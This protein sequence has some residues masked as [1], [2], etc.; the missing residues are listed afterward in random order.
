MVRVIVRLRPEQ[1]DE[2]FRH[3]HLVGLSLSEFLRKSVVDAFDRYR[4]GNGSAPAAAAKTASD[5]EIGSR[6][7]GCTS[8]RFMTARMSVRRLPPPRLAEGISGST[9]AHSSSVKS[10]GYLK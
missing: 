2:L 5:Q 3:L 7:S 6:C 1:Y 4:G 8:R 9:Y 10:L